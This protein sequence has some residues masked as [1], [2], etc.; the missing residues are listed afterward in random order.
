[1]S[2]PLTVADL[3]NIAIEIEHKG[4]AFY[5]VMSRSSEQ[6]AVRQVFHYLTEMERRHV[7]VFQETF[8]TITQNDLPDQEESQYVRYLVDNSVFTDETVDSDVNSRLDT[9]VQAIEL[10]IQMEKDSLLF[11]YELMGQA[12][13]SAHEAIKRIIAEEKSH[14]KQ[15]SEVKKTLE[16]EGNLGGSH[17]A[18]DPG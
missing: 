13:K 15:L 6:T 9:D 11:Y 17:D 14:L 2:T 1:M 7:Q 4:I 3:F 5:D 12:E 18:D 10:G 16:S 8:R